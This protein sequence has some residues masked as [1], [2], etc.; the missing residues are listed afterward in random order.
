M[1]EAKKAALKAVA[2]DETVAD[3]HFALGFLLDSYE[4]DWAGAEREYRRALELDP[5]DTFARGHY[6]QMLAKVGRA[7]AAVAEARHALE[8]DP[9]SLIS[10]YFLS[11]NLTYASPDD[12]RNRSQRYAPESN[13][14]R[15]ITS[16]IGIWG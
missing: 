3:A 14:M 8:P 10:R 2:L 6:A 7:D 13:W 15:T 11:L 1:P 16:T 4:W 5:G 12:F 9:L